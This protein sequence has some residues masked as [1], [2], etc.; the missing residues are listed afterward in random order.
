MENDNENNVIQ[1]IQDQPTPK[2]SS[3]SSL[4]EVPHPDDNDMYI[5][6]LFDVSDLD[7]VSGID[8]DTSDLTEVGDD[9][10]G[11]DMPGTPASFGESE[12]KRQIR[13]TPKGTSSI[14]QVEIPSELGGMQ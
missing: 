8:E 5:K 1:L 11:L 7:N 6:D 9:V 4:F 12:P 13:I 10:L 14:R 2:K 3:M